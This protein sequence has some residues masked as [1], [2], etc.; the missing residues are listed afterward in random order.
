[1]H[2]QPVA[3]VRL[4]LLKRRALWRLEVSSCRVGLVARCLAGGCLGGWRVALVALGA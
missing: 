1:M 4:A 3:Y 2:R